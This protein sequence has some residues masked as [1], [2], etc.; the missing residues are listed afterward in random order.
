VFGRPS[1][2][3]SHR[4]FIGDTPARTIRYKDCNAAKTTLLELRGTGGQTAFPHSLHASGEIVSFDEDGP[5]AHVSTRVLQRAV[6][7]LAATTLLARHWPRQAGS[8]HDL[9]LA[10]A[11][12]LLRGGID[13]AIVQKIIGT[14]AGVAGDPE[15]ADRVAAAVSTAAALA[16]GRPTTG[17]PTLADL[18]APAVVTKLT[19]WLGLGQ[20]RPGSEEEEE[21]ADT[22]GEQVEHFADDPWPDPLSLDLLDVPG[23]P[24]DALPRTLRDRVVD[25]SRVTQTPPDLAATCGLV[26]VGSLGARRVDVAIGRT[27]IEPVNLYGAVISESGTRKGPAQRAMST[28]L[29]AIEASLRAKAAP[30]IEKARQRR[31]IAEKHVEHLSNQAAKASDPA[32]AD[33]LTEEAARLA[34]EL[35][36]VP[37]SQR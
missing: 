35:P 21:G 15:M 9:A 36:H 17:G 12:Y 37:L 31:R 2:P 29:R 34:S 13:P 14:A 32:E 4:E 30:E 11:G 3:R 24:T 7:A 5:P 1:V 27:H 25:V 6:A 33:R 22:D 10:L 26:V 19:R 18:L 20:G 16:A 8:R 28:P 23:F